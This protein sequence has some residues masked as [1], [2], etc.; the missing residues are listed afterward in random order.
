MRCPAGSYQPHLGTANVT[1]VDAV[2]KRPVVAAGSSATVL[3]NGTTHVTRRALEAGAF[4]FS[5]WA[6]LGGTATHTV[7]VTATGYAGAVSTIRLAPGATTAVQIE[8]SS[9][10]SSFGRPRETMHTP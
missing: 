2:T 3:Y 7:H 10:D 9:N 1:V 4:S 6:G 5:G 8:L